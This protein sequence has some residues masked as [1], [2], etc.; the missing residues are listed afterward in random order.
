MFT[1]GQ[2]VNLIQNWDSKGTVSVTPAIVYSCGKK[3]MVLT[4]AVTGEELGRTFLPARE[5]YSKALVVPSADDAQ[6]IALD[7]A[8]RIRVEFIA[9]ETKKI[10]TATGSA[11]Y[12][13]NRRAI[14]EQVLASEPLVI[15]R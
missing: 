6:A 15:E 8:T 1:K 3:Q 13:N 10:E 12:W 4:H 5:Q 2:T 14:L 9:Y 11:E 7:L